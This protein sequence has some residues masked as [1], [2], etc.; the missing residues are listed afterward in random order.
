MTEINLGYIIDEVIKRLKEKDDDKIPVEASGRH[1]HLS[2]EHLEV[3]FGK[4]YK[5][6][7]KRELSQ[8]GQF[9]SVEKVSLT[10][11]K[12]TIENI[13]ILGP[14]REN[15]QAEISKTDAVSI[16]V[17]APVRMSGNIEGSSSVIIS[18][19]LYSVKLLQG[20][21]IAKRH[22]HI[23]PE[24]ADKYGVENN[25]EVNVKVE[26]DRGVVFTNVTVRV[27]KNYC[28]ALHL[29]YDEA[30]ACGYYKGMK[31]TIVK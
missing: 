13:S 7:P 12:G 14:A 3:L 20:V 17:D 9:L 10:G 16:G 19:P 24:D 11:I 29:D 1:V 2:K 18:T 27:G 26:G 25:E 23:T 30:N 21:I 4:D 22:I 31:A 8:P 6:T 5:L 28:T 15:S